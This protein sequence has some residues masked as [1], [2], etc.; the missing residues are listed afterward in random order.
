[1]LLAPIDGHLEN[2]PTIPET[3][4]N[5]TREFCGGYYDKQAQEIV[6]FVVELRSRLEGINPEEI[7][8]CQKR[9]ED[10]FLVGA[11]YLLKESNIK[12]FIDN[13]KPRGIL[14]EEIM[15]G[16][17][18]QDT[19]SNDDKYELE[20]KLLAEQ[21]KQLI[22][23]TEVDPES[24][25]DRMFVVQD[26]DDLHDKPYYD[27][28]AKVYDLLN[29]RIITGL[30]PRFDQEEVL[31]GEVD[32]QRQRLS[33]HVH[34]T[35]DH[36]AKWWHK[37]NEQLKD[38]RKRRSEFSEVE[39]IVGISWLIREKSARSLKTMFGDDIVLQTGLTVEEM[40]KHDPPDYEGITVALLNIN[41]T[42]NNFINYIITGQA[43][44]IGRFEIP[45]EK[46]F[47]DQAT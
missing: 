6:D 10:M 22:F 15:V 39:K 37:L 4:S 35:A 31:V 36:P 43:P 46:F 45:A 40:L 38:F 42:P 32:D 3:G 20:L 29:L 28:D 19:N 27:I 47:V 30:S 25:M 17:I 2:V 21:L 44:T 13:V 34:R 33:L 41:A 23:D 11:S 8:L 26:G 14:L 12:G 7:D 18:L 5:P 1:M 9:F 16:K 24:I